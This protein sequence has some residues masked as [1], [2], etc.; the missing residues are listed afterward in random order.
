M[1]KQQWPEFVKFGEIYFST[2]NPRVTKVGKNCKS[3]H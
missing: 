3:Q 1:L 2:V